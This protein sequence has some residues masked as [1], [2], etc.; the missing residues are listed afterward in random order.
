[1]LKLTRIAS[2]VKG[3]D[4]SHEQK[5]YCLGHI[6]KHMDMIDR[7]ITSLGGLE[8]VLKQL[9]SR[10]AKMKEDYDNIKSFL[11]AKEDLLNQALAAKEARKERRKPKPV[12]A[13]ELNTG[14]IKEYESMNAAHKDLRINPGQIKMCCE[15]INNVK[16]A[17]SKKNG[18]RYHF[19]YKCVS[20]T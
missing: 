14:N 6:N 15:G 8:E 12:I 10:S 19:Y 7:K 20:L 18:Q 2:L 9:G 5:F 4:E 17:L 13:K 3:F 16:T 11:H 1:M